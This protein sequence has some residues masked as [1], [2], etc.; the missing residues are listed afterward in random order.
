MLDQSIEG[1]VSRETLLALAVH[2]SEPPTVLRER[3]FDEVARHLVGFGTPA[4]A[5]AILTGSE[6]K[7]TLVFSS[8][9]FDDQELRFVFPWPPSLVSEGGKCRGSVSLTIVSTPPLDLRFDAEFVRV[10]LEVALQQEQEDGRWKGRLKPTFVPRTGNRAPFE[11]A[12]IEHGLKWSPTKIYSANLRGVG[13][14]S[15]WR[16][17]V[18]YLTRVGERMP[19]TGVPFTVI[20]T[21]ADPS[22]TLP[23][24]NEVRQSLQAIGVQTADV[25]TAARVVPRV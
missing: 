3:A 8:R 9:L 1:D 23:V 2:H 12:L 11:A 13:S 10:N 18:N 24:F 22:G 7:V 25:R 14:S 21:I 19:T 5:D 20:L 15:N 4:A 16:L 6:S 17:S